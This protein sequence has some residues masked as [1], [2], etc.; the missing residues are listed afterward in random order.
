MLLI[1]P[2][3]GIPNLRHSE[4][5]P[6]LPESFNGATSSGNSSQLGIEEFYNDRLLT[7][8]IE[9]ALVD[10]RELKVLNEEVAIA[11]NEILAR[12]GAYL[13]FVSVAAGA[14]LNRPSRFTLDGAALLAD[15]YL[16]GKF[17]GNPHGNY[18]SGINL[19]WQL[20]IYRQLRNAGMRRRSATSPPARSGT[21]S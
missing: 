19:S 8:L 6:G 5:A 17:F 2:F 7:S 9:K 21:I 18:G 15:P 10:N 13:P 1:L 11:A 16:P 4:P 20:D 12:S 3:C 14:G